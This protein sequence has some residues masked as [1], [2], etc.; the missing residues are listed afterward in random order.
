MRALAGKG[1]RWY[2]DLWSQMAVWSAAEAGHKPDMPIRQ[3]A[4]G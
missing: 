3:F 1:A 4:R 2:H